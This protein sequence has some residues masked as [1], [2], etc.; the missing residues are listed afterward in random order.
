VRRFNLHDA[1]PDFAPRRAGDAP[2]GY[3]S[4]A[5][6][7][8]AALGA[9]DLAGKLYELPPGQSVC[10]YHFEYADEEWLLVLSGRPS[11][12]HPGGE[13]E[14]TE[15]DV[16]CFRRGPDGAH[17]VTNRS[18][19]PCRVLIVSTRRFPAVVVY[20]DSD[21]VGVYTR[22]ESGDGLYRRADEVGYWEDEP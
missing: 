12:R 5:V 20:P 2:A 6:D 10:P 9:G 15:G 16:A 4:G 18:D 19:A 1:E 13:D 14:L 11:V 21:K 22:D 17:K 8:G 3:L 7:V